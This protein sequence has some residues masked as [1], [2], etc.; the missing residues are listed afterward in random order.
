MINL[1]T[2]AIYVSPATQA[3]G[4][5]VLG[6]DLASDGTNSIMATQL[7]PVFIDVNAVGGL[8]FSPAGPVT[9]GTGGNLP[10]SSWGWHGVDP[11]APEIAASITEIAISDANG[12]AGTIQL[13][14]N[15]LDASG[16]PLPPVPFTIVN[17]V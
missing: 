1:T 7:G 5:P 2:F 10:S 17:A 16:G 4:M 8:Q 14:L 3:G 9:A 13:Q 12:A 15:L 11:A 6:G